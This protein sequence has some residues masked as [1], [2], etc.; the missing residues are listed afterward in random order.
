M[1]KADKEMLDE[2]I[3]ALDA[4]KTV[5][6]EYK[7]EQQDIYDELSEKSQEGDKG[8]ALQAVLE[9]LET[10]CDNID[11]AIQEINNVLGN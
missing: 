3:N 6:D 5:L 8:Q 9:Q 7:N 2:Q 1:N 11:Y 10:A 4:V